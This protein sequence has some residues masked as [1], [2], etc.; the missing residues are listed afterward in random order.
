MGIRLPKRIPE[1]DGFRGMA[2]LMVMAEHV[3]EVAPTKVA[4][5]GPLGFL[6]THGWLGVDLFF[7]L[8]GFLITGILLDERDRG[9][10]F[11]SF[12][13][14]R[15]CR[16]LPLAIACLIVYSLVSGS[17][18]DHGFFVDFVLT[19]LFCA[20]LNVFFGVLPIPGTGVMWS[21]AVEEHFYLLWPLII[22]SFSRR[23]VAYFGVAIVLAS[24][25]ARGLAMHY[26]V[27]PQSVYQ[28]SW[29]RFDGLAMG[30]LL[31]IFVR[32]HHFTV[33][34]TWVIAVGW[35]AVIMTATVLLTPYGA[36]QA[37]STLGE[38]LR[39]SQ[40]QALFGAAMAVAL[41]HQGRAGTAFLRSRFLGWTAALS[42]CLYMIHM[43]VGA[44]YI[45]AL[46][47]AG[48]S[49]TRSLGALLLR[50]VA[51]FALCFALAMLSGKYLE[52][53]FLRM[54]ARTRAIA[55]A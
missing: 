55:A 39:Y 2:V 20:N 1:L 45:W 26:G 47:E 3:Y 35:L 32:S 9:D 7:V 6:L 48:V 51:V 29:F 5:S 24:P 38:A 36:L 52:G 49:D 15:A 53:P 16:I 14:R 25:V 44:F 46:H 13:R 10:Y 23:I 33:R 34:T 12:Y 27:H 41:A 19:L 11:Q 37:K 31:A 42:Y 40:A 8:S 28:L 4:L 50:Y 18:D 43:S 30:A 21:L 22:R 17:T 54:R